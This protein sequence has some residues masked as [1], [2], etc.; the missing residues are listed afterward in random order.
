MLSVHPKPLSQSDW[1]DILNVVRADPDVASL[2]SPGVLVECWGFPDSVMAGSPVE[3]HSPTHRGLVGLHACNEVAGV[4]VLTGGRPAVMSADGAAD[5]CVGVLPPLDVVALR[6]WFGLRGC[7][8]SL[9]SVLL[10]RSLS[11]AVHSVLNGS[12][13]DWALLDSVMAE[14]AT[15]AGCAA[16]HPALR[17]PDEVVSWVSSVTRPAEVFDPRSVAQLLGGWPD[18][19]WWGVDFL[20]QQ[21]GCE[22]RPLPEVWELLLKSCGSQVAAE[23][24]TLT[25]RLFGSVSR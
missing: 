11:S 12:D 8:T 23:W 9:P 10:R 1:I 17:T 3:M 15:L 24:F 16:C 18:A 22:A 5:T 14:G 2:S 25:S 6:R 4:V 13:P 19:D 21:W 7:R 20:L